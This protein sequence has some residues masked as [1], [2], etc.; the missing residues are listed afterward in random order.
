MKP[1]QPT[2]AVL[3]FFVLG[4]S[5]S[6]LVRNPLTSSFGTLRV[7]S[8]SL[9]SAIRIGILSRTSLPRTA[10]LPRERPVTERY[11]AANGT[12]CGSDR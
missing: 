8:T 10:R 3:A 9:R 12:E 1:I 7:T 5:V 6:L 11:E 4:A 2:F